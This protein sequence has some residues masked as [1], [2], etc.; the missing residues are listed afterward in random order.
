M[1]ESILMWNRLEATPRNETQIDNA[2]R[3]EIRDAL[4]ML[5]RQWQFGELEG[6]D[7][8]TAAF[9]RITAQQSPI[10]AV[11]SPTLPF[12]KFDF[13][14][15]PLELPV[16]KET[17]IPG[18]ADRLE[19]GRHWERMLRK[20]L[21]DPAQ[22]KEAIRQFRNT[23]S[24]QFSTLPKIPSRPE[25]FQQAQRYSDEAALLLA[26]PLSGGRALDGYALLLEL[27]A[28]K[29][30]SGFL[31]GPDPVVNA[32]GQEYLGWFERVYG[33]TASPNTWHPQHLEYQP[34]LVF[35]DADGQAQTLQKEAYF[36]DGLEWHGFA[37]T[38]LVD[39]RLPDLDSEAPVQSAETVIPAGVRF[40]GMPSKRLWEMEDGQVDFGS[41]RPASTELSKML[42][43]EFGLVYGNDW[44]VAPVR[45]SCGSLCRI[46]G[47]V[48]TD[49]F[50]KETQLAEI[51]PDKNWAFF[52]TLAAENSKRWLFLANTSAYVE[53]SKPV[54]KVTFM[55]DEMANM[56]WGVEE[57]IANPYGGGRDGETLAKQ[58][59]Q[60]IKSLEPPAS[61]A[62]TGKSAAEGWAYK[63]GTLMAENRIPFIPIAVDAAQ[64]Q[65]SKLAERRK[66][67][68]QRAASPRV[69]NEFQPVRIRPRTALLGWSG[70]GEHEKPAPQFVYEEEVPRTGM[71][72]SM[73]WK[74]VRWL[75]GQTLTWLARKK[76]VGKGEI[77][78]N[79]RFDVLRKQGLS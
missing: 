11:G 76:S 35:R 68:L 1:P 34:Q 56:V 8:G 13:R 27:R 4:W 44:L 66:V 37:A 43:A 16:E 63:A 60:W 7:A 73:V 23:I 28:G 39:R 9:T 58:T 25:Q 3:F 61:A 59:A 20:R 46:S 78:A 40:R 50:G 32:A 57:I 79:F 74:R 49:I 2:L 21:P 71:E 5:T 42:F 64:T 75:G 69:S 24:L 70:K 12:Q 14:D 54:E 53:E 65:L 47:M 6:E 77:D 10:K 33:Q 22:A 48:M 62:G 55:R 30:A 29:P 41:I 52:Q 17:F 31:A 38:P 67:L 45:F 51:Q 36:G 26:Q 72:L 19:M 15:T 18:I